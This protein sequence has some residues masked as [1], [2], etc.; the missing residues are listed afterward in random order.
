MWINLNEG[1]RGLT[2]HLSNRDGWHLRIAFFWRYGKADKA[3]FY[4]HA[5][6]LRGWFCGRPRWDR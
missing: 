1:G 6:Y 3:Y 2:F 5:G 4:R